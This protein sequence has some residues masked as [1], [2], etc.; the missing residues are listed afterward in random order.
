MQTA[1]I[2]LMAFSVFEMSMGYAQVGIGNANPHP[3]AVLDLTAVNKGLLVP[4][5]TTQQRL[6]IA[7][8]ATGLIVFDTNLKGFQYFDGTVWQ[9]VGSTTGFW[10]SSEGTHIINTNLGRVGIGVSNPLAQLAVDSG[11]LVDQSNSN[12]PSLPGRNHGIFFGSSG[13]VGITSSKQNGSIVRSGLSFYT[14]GTRR[15]VIDSVGRIGIGALPD[16]D[17]QLLLSGGLGNM[18]MT[19]RLNAGNIVSR[20]NVV[21]DDL[22]AVNSDAIGSAAL[23]IKGR[24]GTPDGWGVHII[25]VSATTTDSAAILYDGDGMKLRTFDADDDFFFRNSTNQTTLRVFEDGNVA[26]LGEITS[27]G[28]GVV[29]GNDAN[30]HQIR[31]LTSNFSGGVGFSM[32]SGNSVPLTVNFNLGFS[33]PPFVMGAQLVGCNVI[34]GEIKRVIINPISTTSTQAV[35][36]I[37]NV[38]NGAVNAGGCQIRMALVGPR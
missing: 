14:G 35:V 3:S 1:K 21:V 15:L 31:Y 9:P 2:I 29:L 18:Y 20:G 25:L 19:G 30:S 6:A 38:G 22:L 34:S 33:A 13:L 11:L 32:N 28:R 10:Q 12:N 5:L 26:A 17:Y 8:P 16:P 27:L 7:S 24:T 23:R 4:R 37:I 36:E